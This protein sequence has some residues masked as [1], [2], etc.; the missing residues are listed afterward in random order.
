MTAATRPAGVEL[1]TEPNPVRNLNPTTVGVGAFVLAVVSQLFGLWSVGAVLLACFVVAVAAGRLR[2]FVKAWAPTVLLLSA[3]I[4][5]LQ[6][7]FIPGETILVR[8]WI[9]DATLEGF[10]RGV[11]FAQR[12]MGVATPIVLATQ[13]S[14]RRRV[15]IELERRRLP[16]KATYVV[17]AALNLIPEMGKQL[18]TILDAQRARGV[19]TDA[20][21]F[22]R[23]RAFVPTLIPLILTSVLSVEEKALALQSRGFM[24][25]GKKTALYAVADTR[26]DRVLRAALL[27]LLVLV[28]AGRILL[29]AW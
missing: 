10:E 22:V 15:M 9:L 19:E 11:T 5:T 14:S 2:R 8:V 13:V 17:V 7:L 4:V 26:T 6:T 23:V 20:N 28:V 27:V 3:V 12:I 24:V 25:T 16:P 29:W 18:S 1:V 21:W